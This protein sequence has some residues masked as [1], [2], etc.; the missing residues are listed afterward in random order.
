VVQAQPP[1]E[2]HEQVLQSSLQ[3]VPG[4]HAPTPHALG[5][6]VSAVLPSTVLPST[7]LP[8]TMVLGPVSM[9][10]PSVPGSSTAMLPPHPIIKSERMVGTRDFDIDLA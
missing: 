5:G 10:P 2:E 1:L 3:V 4:V 6:R 7:V 9:S 8:S